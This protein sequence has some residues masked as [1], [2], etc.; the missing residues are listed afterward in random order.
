M[1]AGVGKTFSDVV[2]LDLEALFNAE[3][4][5]ARQRPGGPILLNGD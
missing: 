3:V 1:V 5:D 2:V 4:T